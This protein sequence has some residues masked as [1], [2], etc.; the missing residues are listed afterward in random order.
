VI[1]S[2]V[3]LL[4]LLNLTVDTC[5]QLAFK[6]AATQ[7]TSKDGIEHWKHM[8]AHPWIWLGMAFYVVEFC[9]W[10]AFLSQV[11]LSVGVMLGSFNIVVI[12]LGGR[13]L[14]QER[15]TAWRVAGILCITFGVMLVGLGQ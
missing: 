15:L 6:K 2:L 7:D 9:V 3:F 1:M 12:M 10:T 8:A 4:W 11:E 13:L 14:F 5:G